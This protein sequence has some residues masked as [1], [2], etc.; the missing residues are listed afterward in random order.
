[1]RGLFLALLLGGC[2]TSSPVIW[3]HY[4]LEL[5]RPN[6][7]Q[8]FFTDG[9]LTMLD[10]ERLRH[11]LLFHRGCHYRREVYEI[12]ICPDGVDVPGVRLMSTTKAP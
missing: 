2:A 5:T 7:S 8:R 4:R 1:M 11:E 6:I 10:Y 9:L 12:L 3:H